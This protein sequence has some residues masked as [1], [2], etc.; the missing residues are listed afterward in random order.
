MMRFLK[1]FNC[2]II[3]RRTLLTFALLIGLSGFINAQ[4]PKREFRAVW[5]TTVWRIDWPKTN[6]A[7]AQK[8]EMTALLDQLQSNNIN[9]V[10]FQVRGRCDAF[11]NSAY[12]PWSSDLGVNRGTNPG[13]DPLQF[14]LDE[15]HKRGIEVHAWLNPYR[16]EST[17]NA[18]SNI[19]L[20]G[21]YRYSN[22]DWII[23]YPSGLA[24]LNPGIP[25]VR[26][27][28]VDVVTDI[29]GKYDVDG[30]I[31]DDYFYGSGTTDAMD[32]AQ[33]II[34]N[35]TGMSRANWR[36]DNVNKMIKAVYD[37]IQTIKS[38]ITFGVSPAGVAK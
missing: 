35:P 6:G 38:Y 2:T 4:S 13:Y 33:Y 24:I 27:R 10:C 30:I 31:F 18:W 9:A 14:V 15:A 8:N 1:S 37:K 21:N 19:T 23:D 17:Y 25:E 22:P 26:Q 16:Y 20:K 34:S 29:L 3:M 11:Y 7:T 36:R 12:E 28:I 32:Q 5:L